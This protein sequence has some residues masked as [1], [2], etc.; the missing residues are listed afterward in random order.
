[1]I[2]YQKPPEILQKEAED[3]RERLALKPEDQAAPADCKT[4]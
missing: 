4:Q 2:H 1:V 3:K